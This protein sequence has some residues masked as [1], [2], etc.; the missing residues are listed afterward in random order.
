MPSSFPPP[1]VHGR[2]RPLVQ[3]IARKAAG[4]GLPHGLGLEDALSA[5]W[6]GLLSALKRRSE[7]MSEQCFEAFASFRIRGAILDQMRAFD[8]L[9]RDQR[10]RSRQINRT[11]D[12]LTAQLGRLPEPDEIAN[13]LDL[14]LGAFQE[15][16]AQL[17]ARLPA[18]AD[19]PEPNDL[20][21]PGLTVEAVIDRRKVIAAVEESIQLLP[22]RMALVLALHYQEDLSLREIGEVM[23][24]TASRVC[25]LHKE[26]LSL[27]QS[28]VRALLAQPTTRRRVH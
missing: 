28:N 25:Q 24:L 2:Y 19:A 23:N 16:S 14:P 12:R 7:G 27:V 13:A 1:S 9:S 8:P 15:L 17:E 26:A 10:R 18:G 20:P 22:K 6:L 21:S 11:I 4:G 3:R 5:G